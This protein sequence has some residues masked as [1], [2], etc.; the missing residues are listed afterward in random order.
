[1]ALVGVPVSYLF[2][3]ATRYSHTAFNGKIWPGRILT[4]ATG[5]IIFTTLTHLFLNEAVTWKT[6][7]SLFLTFIIIL[8]QVL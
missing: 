8:L 3:I 6:G 1:M 2:I 5:I 4:F 7:V